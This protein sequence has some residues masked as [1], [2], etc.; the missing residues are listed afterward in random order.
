MIELARND[1]AAAG[2]AR[3]CEFVQCEFLDYATDEAFDIVLAMGYFDYLREP[4]PH[5]AKMISLCRCRLFA[6]FPKR[7]EWRV[8]SRKMR[9][10]LQGGYV[11]FYTKSGITKLLEGAGLS[12]DDT[13]LV[14]LGRDWLLVV[15]L[16]SRR[17]TKAQA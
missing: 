13:S 9:F 14:D 12:E 6:S 17:A 10:L 5:L 11:R 3:Q 7:W 15:N 2:L 4:L 8:P 1:A 16:G